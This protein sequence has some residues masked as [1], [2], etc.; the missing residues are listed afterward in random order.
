MKICCTLVNLG[1]GFELYKYLQLLSEA[2]ISLWND[3]RNVW[4]SKM[5]C[6]SS[7]GVLLCSGH[8]LTC[9]QE[10]CPWDQ[11]YRRKYEGTSNFAR[12]YQSAHSDIPCSE[13][14]ESVKKVA[15]DYFKP[16]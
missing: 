16:R 11:V 5:I 4:G 1:L 3:V 13:K 14:D 9:A 12:Y 8:C 15:K 10:K 6:I 2:F 7:M